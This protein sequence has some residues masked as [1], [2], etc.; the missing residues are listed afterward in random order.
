MLIEPFLADVTYMAWLEYG[1][2][3]AIFV[4]ANIYW[5]HFILML[6]K[7]ESWSKMHRT[8]EHFRKLLIVLFK[9]AW[10]MIHKMFHPP[11]YIC[12]VVIWPDE[13]DRWRH[14]KD[15][16]LRNP[17][18]LEIGKCTWSMILP[19]AP[20]NCHFAEMYFLQT[21]SE[22]SPQPSSWQTLCFPWIGLE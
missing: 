17:P 19:E 15:G 12:A 22:I 20:T 11:C 21:S 4:N 14:W 5:A 6:P 10:Y 16:S 8:G 18:R 7:I 2:D 3:D 9:D 1:V 13:K